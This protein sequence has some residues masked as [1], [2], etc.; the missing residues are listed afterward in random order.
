[1]AEAEL[2]GEL[3]ALGPAEGTLHAELGG[4]PTRSI[5]RRAAR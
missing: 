2:V 1:M 4:E 5:R 3:N